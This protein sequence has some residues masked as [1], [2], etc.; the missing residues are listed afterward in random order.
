MRRWRIRAD[1]GVYKKCETTN[2]QDHQ[3][4]MG[5]TLLRKTYYNK[6]ECQLDVWKMNITNKTRTAERDKEKLSNFKENY[7]EYFL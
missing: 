6:Q 1:H 2:I 5:V 7:P 3:L 4:A